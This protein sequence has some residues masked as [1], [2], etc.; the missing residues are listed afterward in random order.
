MDPGELLDNLY[1]TRIIWTISLQENLTDFFMALQ[2]FYIEKWSC[3][4]EEINQFLR[5]EKVYLLNFLGKNAL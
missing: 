5:G 3:T 2:V 1:S 4:E